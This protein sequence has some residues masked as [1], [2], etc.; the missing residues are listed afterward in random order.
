MV[1]AKELVHYPSAGN[2]K[3]VIFEIAFIEERLK[4]SLKYGIKT[5]FTP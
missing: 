3:E 4:C 2:I 1:S 5:K